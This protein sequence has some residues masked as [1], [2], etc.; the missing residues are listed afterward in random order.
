MTNILLLPQIAGSF[1][2][3][4]NAD[5]R[6]ELLFVDSSNNPL[7]LT[8]IVFHQQW[9]SATTSPLIVLDISTTNG[10]LV[11][12]GVAGTLSWEVPA[13]IMQTVAAGA[14]VGDLVAEADGAVVNLFSST[15][16]ALTVNQGL[17]TP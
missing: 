2:C 5:W 16:A 10:F 15:P 9:R 11:N 8:G 12:G 14:Y 7:D 1:A 13:S 4:N 17:T 3:A 6:D